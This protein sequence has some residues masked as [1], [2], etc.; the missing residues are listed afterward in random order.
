[1]DDNP[2]VGHLVA[3]GRMRNTASVQGKGKQKAERSDSDSEEQL[4]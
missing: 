3:Q 2:L 4:T 1:M